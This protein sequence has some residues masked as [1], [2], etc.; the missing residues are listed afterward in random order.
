MDKINRDYIEKY[1]RELL[2]E[3]NSLKAMEE[4]AEENY[5]PI[6]QP[7]VTQFLKVLLKMKQAKNI[8]EIGTAIAYSAILMAENTS[9]KTQITTIERRED[10]VELARENI[11]ESGYDEKINV[12]EGEALEVL[13]ELDD[14]YD[15]IFL[16]AA[17]GH[18]KEFFD[19]CMRLIE[20]KGIIVCDNVLFRGM[21][22]SDELVV[23]RKITIVKRL[24]EFLKYISDIEGYT[25]SIIPIGDGVALIYREE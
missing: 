16:D 18:Y 25:T 10:M 13:S 20:V 7:E 4:Y 21:V 3:R 11:H 8:L 6:I 14:K 15:F 19:E 1:L 23:R 9:D 22:A 17:K 5:V 2:P 24:R 12:I